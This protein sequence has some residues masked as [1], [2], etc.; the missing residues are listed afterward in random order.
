MAGIISWAVRTPAGDARATLAAL[1]RGEVFAGRLSPVHMSTGHLSTGQEPAG[2][3]V[4]DLVALARE[5]LAGQSCDLI[6]LASTKADLPTWSEAILAEPPVLHGGLAE[7]ATRLGAALG[8]P[9]YALSAACASGPAALAEAARQ[10]R[11]GCTR[12]LV[13]GGDR[14]APFVEAGFAGLGALDAAGCHPFDRD[15]AGIALGETAAA[16]LIGATPGPAGLW[17]QGWGQSLDA[18]H[19]TG[20]A[21]NGTGLARAAQAAC[22]LGGAAP[23]LIVAHGTGTRANDAAELAAYAAQWPT[24]PVTGWKGGTGHSLGAC[25]VTEAALAAEALA[26]DSRAPG[27]VG[28]RQAEATTL[29]PSGA[30]HRPAPWLSTNAGFGGL[31]GAVLLGR[32]APQV[33]VPTP[34]PRLIATASA[35][36][37]PGTTTPARLPRPT[38]REVFGAID[39]TWGRLDGASR[40]L[41][42]LGHALAVQPWPP[43]SAIVLLTDHGCLESDAR[44]ER[45]RRAGVPEFQVFAYTLPSAP[46]GEASIR[47]RLTGPGQVLLGASDAQ[48]R[49]S[50]ELLLADGCP[51][52]LLARVE[53]GGAH[54]LAWAERW[55]AGLSP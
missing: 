10:V 6:L 3:F 46:V 22:A 30:H 40:V 36:D 41:V 50:V 21:R 51:A 33:P 32:Q 1:A 39:P 24:V 42:A 18:E 5:V 2:D 20:P 45:A 48:G 8:A 53:T 54:E 9:A 37:V 17:L 44:F 38:A 47:L 34:A 7:V 23:G 35:A 55:E 4:A 43:G 49:H 28:L 15:R 19:L 31:N 26:T 27:V 11:G 13:L 29:L 16:V 52:V 25:G 12:V 14:L